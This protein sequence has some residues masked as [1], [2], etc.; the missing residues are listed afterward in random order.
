MIGDEAYAGSK[1]FYRFEK[2]VKSIFGYKHIIPTHQGR[3]AEHL[4]FTSTLT[5]DSIVPNNIHFDTNTC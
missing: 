4:L 2:T 3:V 1:S 5:A